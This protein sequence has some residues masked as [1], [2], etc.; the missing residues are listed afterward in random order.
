M[1]HTRTG[2]IARLPVEVREVLNDRLAAGEPA[3]ALVN[4]L[5]GLLSV[6]KVL[7]EYFGSRLIT[8]QNLSEWR[9][10]GHQDWLRQEQARFLIEDLAQ[11]DKDLDWASR[12]QALSDRFANR[13][14]LELFQLAE[15]LVAAETDPLQRW[16]RLCQLNAQLARQRHHDHRAA[17]LQL[18]HQR[19][20]FQ[21]GRSNGEKHHLLETGVGHSRTNPALSQYGV[22]CLESIARDDYARTLPKYRKPFVPVLEPD[23]LVSSDPNSDP[24]QPNPTKSDPTPPIPASRPAPRAS[25]PISPAPNSNP[26][27]DPIQPD[28]TQS[29]PRT[30]K[31]APA[32]G[33]RLSQPQHIDTLAASDH[34]PSSARQSDPRSSI[35]VNGGPGSG[36]LINMPEVATRRFR[37]WLVGRK[38]KTPANA[39]SNP[40]PT[41]LFSGFLAGGNPPGG[42]VLC[43][44]VHPD[45]L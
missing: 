11:Q 43:R 44:S 1:N 29:N 39:R 37:L 28:P 35:S 8:E 25:R 20:K 6:Q 22:D 42:R 41:G 31:S 23:P 19:F 21:V 15:V 17:Q 30:K 33:A 40:P 34:Q 10:G 45:V 26:K 13:V 36:G 16:D 9:A 32:P 27:P 4:W 24:I 5:N 3:A 18:A 14:M 12:G 38:V 2:K 7:Q